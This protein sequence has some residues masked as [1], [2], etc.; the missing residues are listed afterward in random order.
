[1]KKSILTLAIA[2]SWV[3]G[4]SQVTLAANKGR[5]VV[6]VLTDISH[7]N[8]I[9]VRGNIELYLSDGITDNVKVYNSYCSENAL[10]QN[11]NGVL[12]ISSYKKE[13]LVVWVT[14]SNLS[15]LT[16]Y[17]NAQVKSF[18]RLSAVEL[19]VNLYNDASAQLKMDVY[20][21]NMKLHDRVKADL[22][23]TI[24]EANLNCDYSASLNIANLDREHLVKK[25]NL[26][27]PAGG[28]NALVEL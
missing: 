4:I 3:L 27:Y 9:E 5:S 28:T 15:D 23:G 7:I 21:L 20:A 16:V 18:G 6:T 25:V 8:K 13:K 12:K 22:E 17:D 2:L 26:N 24:T 14:V 10:V 11:Q 1:M 19:N